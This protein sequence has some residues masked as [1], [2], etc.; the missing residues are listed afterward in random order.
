MPNGEM[1]RFDR[2]CRSG[3]VA[4]KC[5]SQHLEKG[6]YLTLQ[7]QSEMVWMGKATARLGLSGQAREEHFSLLCSGKHPFTGEKLGA[8]DMGASRRVCYFGQIS[9]PNDISI[10][11]QVGGDERIAGWRNEA[12]QQVLQEIESATATQVRRGAV[13]LK[14]EA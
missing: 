4:M 7:G 3:A 11:Y 12:V 8:R 13:I 9:A 10:A 1:I 5:L 14:R 6:N 2:P